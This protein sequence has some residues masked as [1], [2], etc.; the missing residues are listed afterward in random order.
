MS[1]DE[2]TSAIV[3][4]FHPRAKDLDGLAKICAQV[5]LLVVVDNGSTENELAQI[6][7]AGQDWGFLLLE[8][9]ENLGIAA[10][11]N[12]GVGEAQKVGCKWVGLFDQDSTV[13][14]GFIETMIADFRRYR[15]HKKIMQIVPRYLDPETGIERP[16]S[17]FEDGGI[18]LTC[19]SGSLF[20][21]EAFERCGL[22][23]ENLFIYCVDD[24]YSLRI[25]K[26]GFFIG[27]S[28]NA[29]L[30]HRSGRPTFRKMFGRTIATK[31]YRPEVRYYYARNKVWILRFYAKTF[32]RIIVPTLREFVTIP[33]KIALMEDES[34]RKIKLF[35][36]GLA[37]GVSGR[38]GPLREAG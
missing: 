37:D 1:N 23:Q 2:L 32:P 8:N 35:I 29:V 24:D 3:V 4:T 12:L 26:E 33:L 31:N 22:F 21:M 13:T 27:E 16:V 36:R 25:R 11:L 14:E 9:G 10:A 18:F 6:R 17:T 15:E 7:R 38:M 30:L 34:W 20:S 19:T 5:D 28:P